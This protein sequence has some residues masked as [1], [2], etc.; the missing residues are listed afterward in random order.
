M[1]RTAFAVLLYFSVSSTGSADVLLS[2]APA[3]DGHSSHHGYSSLITRDHIQTQLDW[4][5]YYSNRMAVRRHDPLQHRTGQRQP[6]V[7]RAN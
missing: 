5:S 4:R 2:G 1:F 3:T 6:S 7:D